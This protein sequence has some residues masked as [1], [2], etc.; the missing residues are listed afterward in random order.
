LLLSWWLGHRTA[1]WCP[2]ILGL[3]PAI[4][5]LAIEPASGALPSG[6]PSH[7]WNW[8]GLLVL[9]SA[10][11]FLEIRQ[12]FYFT[13]DDN[14][15]ES[16]PL[17]VLGCR[18]YWASEFPHYNPYLFL[19][20]P[21]ASLGL[22]GLTYPPTVASY[23]LARH[24]LQNEY[25]TVDV[26]AI[27][28]L[29]CGFFV[30]RLLGRRLGMGPVPANLTALSCDLSG[31]ALIMGRSWFN[32]V[33]ILVWLPLLFLGLLRLRETE[34]VGWKWIV[35]MALAMAAPFH[36]G[37]S[38]VAVYVSGFFCLAVAF[39]LFT[40]ALQK[41]SLLPVFSALLIGAAIALPLVYQQWI[42]AQGAERTLPAGEGI[43]PGL[44]A[45]LLPYPLVQTQLPT[46]WGN[47]HL[48]TMGQ[49]YFF[50]GVLAFLFFVQA[51]GLLIFRPGRKEW[52]GQEW[53]FCAVIALWLSL[54]DVG[55]LWKV[56]SSLPGL[57]FIFR[58][59][60][61]M[62]PFVVFFVSI[63]GGLLL[64]RIVVRTLRVRNSAHGV[65]GLQSWD[66]AH[67]VCGLQSWNTAHG[68]CGL[69]CLLLLWHVF[70][71]QPAFY[72]YHAPIYPELPERLEMLLR[73]NGQATAR[74]M[75][76]TPPAS[77]DS[78]FFAL[79]P[80]DLPA[81]Y[82]LPIRG[83]Y[84]PLL[85][86][87]QPSAG[88]FWT[89]TRVY[90]VA[91]HFLPERPGSVSSAYSQNWRFEVAAPIDPRVLAHVPEG[92]TLEQLYDEN[93]VVVK[94]LSPVDP[95]AFTVDDPSNVSGTSQ[96][97]LPIVM[98]GGGVDVN[99]QGVTEKFVIVN[100]R[101]WP[102]MRLF[103]WIDTPAHKPVAAFIDGEPVMCA[104]DHFE[105]IIVPM[106]KEGATLSI[107]YRAPWAMGIWLGM[108]T[109]AAGLAVAI[110]NAAVHRKLQAPS[111]AASSA[112]GAN[113][114][115]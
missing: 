89:S 9:V 78:N 63:S 10:L 97:A 6:R 69:Q 31:A 115:S 75:P 81:V 28:H 98:H 54:G 112:N 44:P 83:G 29:L 65:C 95:L 2:E 84:N 55:V 79:L 40:G 25:A 43:G 45:L 105:R 77:A 80:Q 107:R 100:F 110:I 48:E 49:F 8:L 61:R 33:P 16:L 34:K 74:M 114:C 90:G 13:Q 14:A 73:P 57:G 64:E 94:K 30:I 18:S 27:T 3:Q 56:V 22:Y 19:G 103:P 26:Y 111:A 15:T 71:C 99:I 35:G 4:A 42:L 62:M 20:S 82:R 108:A 85:G 91:W 87:K 70:L 66:A 59:P 37:F 86:G 7:G 5:N 109:A 23:A 58:Y 68:V 47:E 106:P 67:G 39:L 102:E 92:L 1:P 52:A 11:A 50:G 21:L 104:K 32:F 60:M 17:I 12:P 93:G 36:V 88:D 51:T 41:R 113:R 96:P 101:H 24:V 46:G 72:V 38:Q 53:I 76:W